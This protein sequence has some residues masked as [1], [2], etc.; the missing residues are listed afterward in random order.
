MKAY[1]IQLFMTENDRDPGA[2]IASEIFRW[3]KE[4]HLS[5]GW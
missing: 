2:N 3:K 5:K 4:L 1:M